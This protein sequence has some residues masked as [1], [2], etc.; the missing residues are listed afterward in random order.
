LIEDYKIGKL[1]NSELEVIRF[2]KLKHKKLIISGYNFLYNTLNRIKNQE[3]IAYD[4]SGK[5]VSY[6]LYTLNYIINLL[7]R[8]IKPIFIF[9]TKS[10]KEKYERTKLKKK[11]LL[12]RYIKYNKSSD[13]TINPEKINESYVKIVEDLIN[14]INLTGCPAFFAP[15]DLLP[16]AVKMIKERIAYSLITDGYEG[17]IF[18]IPIILRKLDFD[19]DTAEKLVLK[20]VL[21]KSEITFDQF[22]EILLLMGTSYFSEI[23]KKGLGPKTSLNLIKESESINNLIKN[24]K[25]EKNEKKQKDKKNKK[26][27]IIEKIKEIDMP[28][29]KNSFKKPVTADI[30]VEFKPPNVQKIRNFLVHRGFSEPDFEN[31]SSRIYNTHEKFNL[32]AKKIEDFF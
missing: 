2:G 26:I 6:I 31:Y 23:D 19:N 30:K 14:F 16:Q 12:N 10:D 9:D 1:V 21:K 3:F 15:D 22:L 28:G 27:K 20:R 24:E 8:K 11:E 18:G 25:N 5:P 17:L 29:V 4:K 7:E 13:D 32:R